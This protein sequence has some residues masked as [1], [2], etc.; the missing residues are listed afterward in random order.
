[1]NHIT[2]TL[3]NINSNL[4]LIE[5]QNKILYL[6]LLMTYLKIKELLYVIIVKSCKGLISE[7]DL[8]KLELLVYS[9]SN[10]DL[11]TVE[12]LEFM[13]SIESLLLEIT[14]DE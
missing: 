7:P 6:H 10:L 13:F 11:S 5:H 14:K 8:K 12:G 2:E 1:M 3:A 9:K 4:N